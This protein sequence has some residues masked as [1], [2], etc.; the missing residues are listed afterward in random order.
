LIPQ[1]KVKD[2]K[3]TPPPSAEIFSMPMARARRVDTRLGTVYFL[4]PK[5][6]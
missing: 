3:P 1:E 6:R 5:V 2:E 4:V